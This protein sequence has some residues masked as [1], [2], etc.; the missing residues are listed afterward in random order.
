MV[1]VIAHRPENHHMVFSCDTLAHA[2]HNPWAAKKIT[3]LLNANDMMVNNEETKNIIKVS[4][5]NLTT[6]KFKA[7]LQLGHD[8]GRSVTAKPKN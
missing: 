1:V 8:S 3:L 5:A 4:K 7:D 6:S 2:R